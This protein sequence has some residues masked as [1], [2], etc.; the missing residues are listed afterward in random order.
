[1]LPEQMLTAEKNH[2]A[3]HPQKLGEKKQMSG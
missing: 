2:G 3:F 1:M